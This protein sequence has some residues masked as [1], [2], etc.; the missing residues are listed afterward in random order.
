MTQTPN[1]TFSEQPPELEFK[2]IKDLFEFIPAMKHKIVE[3]KGGKDLLIK[4]HIVHKKQVINSTDDLIKFNA[5]DNSGK[6][7]KGDVLFTTSGNAKDV[8]R[9]SVID[10]DN[11]NLYYGSFL[12]GLRPKDKNIPSGYLAAVLNL[13]R[14]RHQIVKMGRASSS[15][16]NIKRDD[17]MEVKIQVYKNENINCKHVIDDIK[18]MAL[19]TNDEELDNILWLFYRVD[20]LL[21]A[22][23]KK[24]NQLT[25]A[26]KM[27]L[28]S[29]FINEN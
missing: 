8:G 22:Y 13:P 14:T 4:R 2:K 12:F 18:Q 21:D 27:L 29:M 10:I 7:Q 5:D 3:D 15:F 23:N 20:K 19:P 28:D 9:A 26:K 6:V 1:L 11:D 24:Y 17:L 16:V 25:L